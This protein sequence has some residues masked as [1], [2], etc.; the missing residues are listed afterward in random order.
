MA[1]RVYPLAV[2]FGY[3]DNGSTTFILPG[4]E[5]TIGGVEG[6]LQTFLQECTGYRP[7]DEIIASVAEN[8][9]VP[10]EDIEHLANILLEKQIVVNALEY[11]YLFH[12]VSANPMPFVQLVTD[13]ELWEMLK[14]PSPLVCEPDGMNS[15]PL[16]SLLQE[17]RSSR[18]FRPEPLTD[19]EL[20]RLTWVAHGRLRRSH[21][22]P[23][24]TTGLGTVPSGG[25]LYPL[26]LHLI[27]LRGTET[28]E[29][30]VYH[31]GPE[32]CTLTSSLDEGHLLQAFLGD[33]TNAAVVLVVT[34]DFQ[35]TTQKYSNR[36]YRYALLEAGHVA[37]NVYLWCAEQGLGTV[38]VGGFRDK[39]LADLLQLTYPQEAPLI[40]MIVG[41][42]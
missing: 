2:A 38:E 37:Q 28:R 10:S 5:V 13:E 31:C 22:L 7:L 9:E 24:S 16:E 42:I 40:A 33:P 26:R 34:C 30:G 8:I 19:D 32:G 1:K 15:S 36:G 29:Q 12:G 20:S 4:K 41:R 25:A 35:Q 27:V 18:E 6:I 23:E 3:M 11:Y 17:R 39:E 21:E 14:T